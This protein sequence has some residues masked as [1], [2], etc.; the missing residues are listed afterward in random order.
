MYRLEP[1]ITCSSTPVILFQKPDNIGFDV[2][3]DVKLF[4]FGLSFE[5]TEDLSAVEGMYEL[6]GNTGSLRYMAPE[7]ALG[8]PYNHKV[9]IYSFSILFWQ[10]SHFCQLLSDR[11]GSC[12]HNDLIIRRVCSRS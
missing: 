7:V 10:V 5:I 2:R 12:C 6:S 8:N 3:G 1:I 9:D 4:D 11:F